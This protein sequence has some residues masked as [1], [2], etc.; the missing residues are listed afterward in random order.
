MSA[1][2]SEPTDPRY[3]IND[4]DHKELLAD[5]RERYD[6]PLESF[7]YDDATELVNAAQALEAGQADERARDEF[8]EMLEDVDEQYV[9]TWWTDKNNGEIVFYGALK[10]PDNDECY[11]IR[12]TDEE[13]EF[14]AA[15]TG[16]R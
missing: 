3:D 9:N 1:A 15:P 11:I 13:D 5:I 12:D 6:E 10:D 4:V 7:P 16:F 2:E 8:E 14:T